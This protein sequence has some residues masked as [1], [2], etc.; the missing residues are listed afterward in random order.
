M[1][2]AT[3]LP[4]LSLKPNTLTPDQ[5]NRSIKSG[6]MLRASPSPQA[7]VDRKIRRED[8]LQAS[9][10]RDPAGDCDNRD[11]RRGGA[12]PEDGGRSDRR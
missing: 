7:R 3:L 2:A 4:A 8:R 5:I 6:G 11:R 9:H 1:I 10:S 12:I